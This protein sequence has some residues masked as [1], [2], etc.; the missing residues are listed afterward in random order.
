MRKRPQ[1]LYRGCALKGRP[2]FTTATELKFKSK[3]KISHDLEIYE[4]KSSWSC[5]SL[6][7]YQDNLENPNQQRNQSLTGT[8]FR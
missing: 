4:H 8:E 3:K 6:L 5:K 7:S 2:T 1:T